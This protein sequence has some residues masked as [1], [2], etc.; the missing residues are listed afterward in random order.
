MP[1]TRKFGS[2]RYPFSRYGGE[3]E[4]A[5]NPV[6]TSISYERNLGQRILTFAMCRTSLTG[7]CSIATTCRC[8]EA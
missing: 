4:R 5:L 7:H 2:R 6:S 1:T 3:R 8:Y